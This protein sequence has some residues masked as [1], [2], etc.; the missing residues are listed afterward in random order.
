MYMYLSV[1][2]TVFPEVKCPNPTNQLNV[3]LET[4]LTLCIYKGS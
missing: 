1:G 2:G 4:K 3:I